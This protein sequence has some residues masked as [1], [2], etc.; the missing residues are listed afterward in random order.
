MQNICVTT[1]DTSLVEQAKELAGKLGLNFQIN[2]PEDIEGA[3]TLTTSNLEFRLMEND[4]SLS[5]VKV[6][7]IEGSFG[8]RRAH[9][10]NKTLRQAVGIKKGYRPQIIDATGGF[11]RDS[12]LM[13][14][15]G[16]RITVC[17]RNPVIFALLED[18][19]KRALMHSATVETASKITL[20]KKDAC[21]L[22]HEMEKSGKLVEVVYLDPMYPARSKSA[23]VKKELQLL[24]LLLGHD[25]ESNN[26]FDLAMQISTKRVVVKRPQAASFLTKISPSY[27][28]KGKTTRFDIYLRQ[29]KTL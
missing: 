19:L 14:L 11:G 7:F 15:A 28:L 6:D 2:C 1:C 24:Q 26:L 23:K 13:A 9:G 22:F 21:S 8:Y 16:C 29:Q 4:K 3:L 17:E 27:S 18:G 5:T 10:G 20:M 12:F 25:T